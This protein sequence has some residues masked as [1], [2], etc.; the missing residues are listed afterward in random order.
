[1]FTNHT[2]VNKVNEKDTRMSSCVKLAFQEEGDTYE[3]LH[4]FQ[5]EKHISAQDNKP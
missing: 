2:S 3:S 5:P 4:F 1:M